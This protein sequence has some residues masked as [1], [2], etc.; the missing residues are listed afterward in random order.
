M[1]RSLGY[2]A[3]KIMVVLNRAGLQGGGWVE[4][5]EGLDAGDRV[6]IHPDRELS[7]DQR[8]RSR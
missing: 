7:D 6:V 4:V 1:N 8:V 2:P 3:D 5:L